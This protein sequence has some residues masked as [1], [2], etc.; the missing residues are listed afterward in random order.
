[1]LE[2]P[3]SWCSQQVAACKTEVVASQRVGSHKNDNVKK[4]KTTYHINKKRFSLFMGFLRNICL[5]ILYF[6]LYFFIDVEY[7][8]SYFPELL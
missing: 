3:E 8:I 2:K 1:V 4:I 6:L 7:S 5:C